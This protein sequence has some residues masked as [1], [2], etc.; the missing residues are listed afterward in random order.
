M[1]N[2]QLLFVLFLLMPFIHV[3]GQGQPLTEK[4]VVSLISFKWRAI[5]MGNEEKKMD[6]PASGDYTI[7]R[8]DYTQEEKQD[9]HVS[10]GTWRYVPATKKI[11]FS[12]SGD[13]YVVKELT[14]V[15]LVIS[16]EMEGERA[17]IVFK[18]F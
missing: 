18:H 3:K 7:F 16:V 13:E 4:E 5:Q 14:A 10:K 1:K 8:S 17:D 15:K 11:V 6:I 12:P 2:L 9:D